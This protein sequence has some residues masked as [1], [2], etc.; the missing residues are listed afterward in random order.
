MLNHRLGDRDARIWWTRDGGVW[1]SVV[2][3]PEGLG[4]ERENSVT[5]IKMTSN[6]AN[7][8]GRMGWMG[9]ILVFF[10]FPRVQRLLTNIFLSSIAI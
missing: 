7:S 6:L 10:H 8:G 2:K 5:R 4:L 9:L 1:R 3:V